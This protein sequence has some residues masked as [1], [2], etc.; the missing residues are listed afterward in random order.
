[1]EGSHRCES[2][3]RL[4]QGYQ[5][6]DPIPLIWKDINISSDCTLFKRVLTHVYYP[7]EEGMPLDNKIRLEFKRISKK[8]LEQKRMIVRDTWAQW[9]SAVLDKIVAHVELQD[10]LYTYQREFFQE[11]VYHRD[12]SKDHVRSNQIKKYLHEILTN[13]IFDWS[14]GK[15]LVSNE[16]KTS[17]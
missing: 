10:M 4:L 11:D 15:D 13:V 6:G 1:M 17:R 2:S 14:P 5:L 3:C 7:K 9:I 8:I 16:K 12:I